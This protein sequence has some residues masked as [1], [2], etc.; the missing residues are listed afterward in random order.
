MKKIITLLLSACLF[1]A[2]YA[3]GHR[4]YNERNTRNAP[5][6]YGT[7]NNNYPNRNVNNSRSY[8]KQDQVEKI[9]RDFQYKEMAIQQNRYMSNRQ[10]RLSIRDAKNERDYNMQMLNR[11]SNGY[12]YNNYGK[13]D[14]R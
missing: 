9:N 2:T 1:T 6:N 3:Q 13:Y 8:Q 14:K 10:K 4:D 11:N 7:Y 5:N 12:T